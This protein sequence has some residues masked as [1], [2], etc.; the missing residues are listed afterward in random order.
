V[1]AID[2]A[3]GKWTYTVDPTKVAYA[4]LALGATA[5]ENFTVTVTDEHGAQDQY[6]LTV[7]ATGLYNVWIGTPN[8]DSDNPGYAPALSV[9]EYKA[10]Q[11]NEPWAIFGRGG[12]DKLVGGNA[13]DILV[14]EGGMDTMDG[15][16]G[17]DTYLIGPGDS[18]ATYGDAFTDTGSTGYDRIVAT[19]NNTQIVIRALSGIEEI[20]SGGFSGVNIAGATSLHNVLDLSHTK[21]VGIGEVQGEAQR[22][23]T[24]S[25]P[26]T[27]AM[28][29]E[30]RLTEGAG[31]DT[32]HLG[33]QSTR[34]LVSSADNGGFDNFTDNKFGDAAV[35][36]IVVEG[37]NTQVGLATI[38]GGDK[39]VDVIDAT[40]TSNT[41]LVGS[42]DH[43]NWDLSTTVLKGISVVDV[44]GGNDTVRTAVNTDGPITYKGGTGTDTL[45]ISLTAARAADPAILVAIANLVPGSGVNGSVNVGGLNFSAEG[46]KTSRLASP[47]AIF[48]CRSTPQCAG[49]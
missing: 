46:L 27:T 43:N 5:H 6:T 16:N 15:G 17:S 19:A 33:S 30:V 49:G 3:T 20:N 26:R 48:I 14:G 37:N 40:G 35:H 45:F 32:F 34:L 23:M 13:D 28:R 21:L 24:P 4:S 7:T 1:F 42:G 44:G 47:L 41:S 22:R 9:P 12:D 18:P 25:T 8:H 36:T 10:A 11:I 2:S 38:Y 39:T 31:N 29:W